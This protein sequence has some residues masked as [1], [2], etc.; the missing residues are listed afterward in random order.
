MGIFGGL[1]TPLGEKVD[2]TVIAK[3]TR[4]TG[5]IHTDILL[6]ID[7]EMEGEVHSSSNV[8]VSVN[9][10]YHG[11][12]SAKHITVSGR[13]EGDIRCERLE[14]LKNG[15][16][17]G[18]AVVRELTVEPGGRFFGQSSEAKPAESGA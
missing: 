10:A 7:G 15:V 16:V 13:M 14:I 5:V 6:M 18:E 3:G 8:S 1:S 4:V 9:G 12:I 11:K 17:N 2:K